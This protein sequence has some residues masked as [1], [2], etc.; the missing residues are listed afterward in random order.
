MDRQ[1]IERVLLRCVILG[2]AVII[3]WF[4]FFLVADGLI[5]RVHGAA[6]GEITVHQFQIIHYSGMA[7]LK[8]FITVFFFFPYVALRWANKNRKAHD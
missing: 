3:I 8:L 1:F 2:I 6:F 5:Y 7:L 4:V